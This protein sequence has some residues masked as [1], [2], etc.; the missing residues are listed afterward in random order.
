MSM[1]GTVAY[2]SVDT[3]SEIPF[4]NSNEAEVTPRYNV[5]D[6][7]SDFPYQIHLSMSYRY[8]LQIHACVVLI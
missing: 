8:C 3:Q 5:C 1:Q 2:I 7:S 6:F 4:I